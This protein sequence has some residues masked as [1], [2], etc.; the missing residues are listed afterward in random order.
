[1]SIS[2]QR[3]SEILVGLHVDALTQILINQE[4]EEK[5]RQEGRKHE[6]RDKEESTR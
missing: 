1:M 3:G 6:R 5:E 4:E 2:S